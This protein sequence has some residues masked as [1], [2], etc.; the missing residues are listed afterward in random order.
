M[1]LRASVDGD[2]TVVYPGW[3]ALSLD[4]F[5]AAMRT[6]GRQVVNSIMLDM[7]GSGPVLATR[8]DEEGDLLAACS[9]A[10]HSPEQLV[11][12]GLI[13]L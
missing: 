9:V 8:P 11:E 2:E 12:R 1:Q 3:P 13:R 6:A 7:Y 4:A 5:A 10:F